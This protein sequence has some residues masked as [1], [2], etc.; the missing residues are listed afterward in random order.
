[1]RESSVSKKLMLFLSR[2]GAVLF[3]NNVGKSWISSN[4]VELGNGDVLV[5]NARRFH[6]GLVDGSLDLVGWYSIIITPDMVGSKVAVFTAIDSKHSNGGD[7][8][9]E[10]QLNFI[11]QVNDAGGIAGFASSEEEAM[12]VLERGVSR[13]RT[14]G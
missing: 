9:K 6:S 8:K 2:A 13:L 10:N 7:R 3:R 14:N 11:Y 5:K 1:M 12:Q 4:F